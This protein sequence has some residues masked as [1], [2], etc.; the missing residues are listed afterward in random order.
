M[1]LQL[2]IITLIF[3]MKFAQKQFFWSKAKK[4]HITI[5]FSIFKSVSIRNFTSKEEF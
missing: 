2:E 1:K 4:A 3:T 5:E